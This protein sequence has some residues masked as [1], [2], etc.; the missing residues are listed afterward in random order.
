MASSSNRPIEVAHEGS[1]ASVSQ[2]HALEGVGEHLSNQYITHSNGSDMGNH[3]G[4]RVGP[5]PHMSRGPQALDPPFQQMVVFFHHM[6]E[7]MHDPN[8]I[9]FEKMR[10]MG[11]V[12]FEGT[13]DPIDVEQWLEHMERVFEQ[14]ECPDVAKF[15][16]SIS[17]LQKDAYDWWESVLNAKES[18]WCS[19]NCGSFD[20]KVKDCPNPHNAPSLKTEGSV[21]KPSI[22][23]PQTNRGARLKN[24]QAAGASR[25]NKASGPRATARTYAMRQRD[26]QDGQDVVVDKFHLFGLC[27]FTLID[28][29]ST[30]SY[31][32][33]S[34]VLPKNVKSMRL[35]Y[36]VLVKSPL[37]YQV[38]CN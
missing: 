21:H 8:R 33:S 9:S 29:G 24:T 6:A 35:I 4:I 32:C 2:P 19:F 31:I 16:Y 5:H 7:S 18:F 1:G 34:L 26:D 23:P 22:N 30:H 20:H 10:K 13:V 37:G 38:M 36:D 28:L 11:I 27:V 12:E 14:L 15:K 3:Q 25:A 17:L